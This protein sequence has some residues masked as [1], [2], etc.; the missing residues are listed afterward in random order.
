MALA[1]PH[2]AQKLT[3]DTYDFVLYG[4]KAASGEEAKAPRIR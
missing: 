2:L 4:L 3:H 1:T